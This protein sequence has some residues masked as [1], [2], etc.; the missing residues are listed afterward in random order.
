MLTAIRLEMKDK[1]VTCIDFIPAGT[2]RPSG[3]YKECNII[4]AS[5]S[6]LFV[7]KT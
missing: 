2:N 3:Y 4:K 6:I 5:G 7:S 1:V